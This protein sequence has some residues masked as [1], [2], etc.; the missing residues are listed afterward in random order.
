[1][2]LLNKSTKIRFVILLSTLVIYYITQTTNTKTPSI[3]LSPTPT[4]DEKI[5]LYES[6]NHVLGTD[7]KNIPRLTKISYSYP[8]RGDITITWAI[9]QHVFQNSRKTNVQMDAVNILKVLENHKTRFVYVILIG[10]F[11]TQDPL[12][13]LTEIQAINLGF[14]KSKLDKINWADFHSSNIYD[15]AD[16]AK[17]TDEWK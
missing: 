3:T 13:N 16:V 6:I 15:L 12:A 4:P 5:A 8:E 10:T 17:I 7:N 1:M 11:S 9:N 14:N 2:K